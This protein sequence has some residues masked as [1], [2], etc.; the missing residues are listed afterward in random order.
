[1]ADATQVH[2]FEALQYE[3]GELRRHDAIQGYVVTELCDANWEANGLLDERRGP[4][5]FHERLGVLNALDVVVADL[6][7][8]DYH[9]GDRIGA[10]V[11]LSSYG[12]PARGGELTWWLDGEGLPGDR[13]SSR[14]EAWPVS[15]ARVVARIDV[16]TTRVDTACD[17]VLHVVATDD[18]GR[19]RARNAYRI[20]LVPLPGRV[21]AAPLDVAVHD[22]SGIWGLQG[23]IKALAHR[24]AAR[25]GSGVVV[26]T[27]LDRELLD[28]VERGGRALLL[29]RS[30]QAIAP[31]LRLARPLTIHPRE[32]V[33]A[34]WPGDRSPWDGDWVTSWSWIRHDL[35]QGLP[36]RAPLDFAYQEVMPDHVLTGYDPERDADEVAAGMFAGWVHAPA[37]LAW[38]FPQGAGSLTVTTFRVAPE[39]GPVAMLL[40]DRLV[41][42]A[43]EAPVTERSALP[44]AQG[45]PA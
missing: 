22:P 13:I 1:M 11:T 7:R 28:H 6:D 32:L 5:V 16:A 25:D 44:D 29:V 21:D 12:E 39:S 19:D 2:Q 9:G 37:A 15:G 8:R 35:L 41:R 40:L 4:K 42:H 14:I 24:P 26:A 23:R 38:T 34:D 31:G 33:H 36:E 10:D 27:E 43:A 18:S 45:S 3:I 20:A 30:R 17:A